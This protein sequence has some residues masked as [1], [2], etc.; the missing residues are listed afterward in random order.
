MLR[1]FLTGSYKP[2]REFNWGVVVLLLVLTMLMSFTG[3]L[4]PWDQLAIWT[5]TVGSNM[6]TATPLLGVEGPMSSFIY[7][8]RPLGLPYHQRRQT[9]FPTEAAQSRERLCAVSSACVRGLLAS[10]THPDDDNLGG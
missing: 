10:P 1:V 7:L 2:P 9:P 8:Y 5:V 3:Y 4:L 6:V